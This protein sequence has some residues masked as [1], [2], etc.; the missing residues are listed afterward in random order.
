[1]I[2]IDIQDQAAQQRAAERIAIP[3]ADAVVIADGQPEGMDIE[4]LLRIR[5]EAGDD[6][7]TDEEYALLQA[8]MQQ[9]PMAGEA[10]DHY[11]N[12]AEHVED[13][14]L[15]KISR[16]V[17]GWV[18]WDEESRSEWYD[19][20]KTG[21]RALGVSPNVDGGA[22][23]EGAS[24]VVHPILAEAVTQ[25]AARALEQFWPAGGPV[26][27]A[28]LGAI[29][30][31]RVEQAKRVE[32][33]LNYQY[34]VEIEGAFEQTDKM[35]IRLPISGSCFVKAYYDP[36]NGIC[37]SM[38][39]PADFLVP[40]KSDDLR[41]AQRYTERIMLSQNDLRKRQ[42]AG[43]YR[44][45]EVMRPFERGGS[46]E[47][48]VVTDEIKATEGRD[49]NHQ[50]TG[51]ERH[52]LYECY[53]DLDLPGFEDV[54]AGG[55]TTGV[56]LP[57]IVTV[58]RDSQKVLSIYRNWKKT[59]PRKRRIVYHTH[60]R[61]MPGLGFYGFGLY[62]WIGGLSAAAT[63]ALRA[64]LDS[65]QF[66]NLQG[67]FRAKD[68]V[69]PNGN[70][71]IS[72]GT[73]P[74]VDSDADELK[75][76]FFP[77]PYKE[78]SSVLFSLMG[79]LG[80]IGGRFAGTLESITGEGGQNV[81]VGTTLARIEQGAKVFT[82][83]QTRLHEAARTE[84]A[85]VAWL[86][87]IWMP[88]EYPYAVEGEDRKVFRADFDARI[89]VV[90]ASDPNF[91]SN[92]QRYFVSQLVMELAAQSPDLY[93]RYE[94]NKRALESLKVQNIDALL[95]NRKDQ[96]VRAD[97]VTENAS[98]IVG[99]AI[100]AFM[101]QDHASHLAVHQQALMMLP[102]KHQA[103]PVIQAHIQEHIALG[104]LVQ[105]TQA[106]G[107]AFQMPGEAPPM[108]PEVENQIAALAA[109]AAQQLSRPPEPSPEQIEADAEQKRKDETAAA[110]IARKDQLAAASI[111]RD[112]AKA[113]AEMKREAIEAAGRESSGARW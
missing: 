16:D 97:P 24:T 87:S 105:M 92:I 36:V 94:V 107:A 76:A 2:D 42:V 12:L 68:A 15:Q 85:L 75:K 40:Y 82:S 77:L 58:D 3:D 43:M 69:L 11:A 57:Y 67:G 19:K 50:D 70:V 23:F 113:A 86:D 17:L 41:T 79:Y 9:R 29:D 44:D 55:Q 95:P 5:D 20:E 88:Q 22:K 74:E 61:F 39:E 32:Q 33:F 51:D 30:D 91:V 26:R 49:D 4:A 54:G 65:A 14:H 56:A 37:R 83:I 93:D 1:M 89:D 96:V 110:E 10:S 27:S 84:Y 59:D 66:A 101:D 109:Q 35:L 81:P 99:G 47:R 73:W 46:D 98:A 60:Y 106:T 38:V 53:C 102:D 64:L 78:P 6:A 108:P 21:I 103:L 31:E 28:V 90:P 63:G 104:Y 80:E 8:A 62:H 34:T 112:D 7:L 25:F 45:I 48:T 52:T 111:E 100:K 18:D 13:G 72:P 71:T